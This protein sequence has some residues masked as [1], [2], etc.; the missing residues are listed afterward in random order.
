M[1]TLTIQLALAALSLFFHD[2]NTSAVHLHI[3]N[4]HGI[5]DDDG[6]IQLDGALN[7]CL[8]VRGDSMNDPNFGRNQS[9]PPSRVVF[10]AAKLRF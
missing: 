9:T 10:L 3:R 4:R 5:A 1:G 7:L 8:L 6:Q 2:G